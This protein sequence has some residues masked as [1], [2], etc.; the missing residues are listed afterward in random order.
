[1]FTGQKSIFKSGGGTTRKLDLGA[2]AHYR[3]IATESSV[4]PD[5]PLISNTTSN[6]ESSG[7]KEFFDFF[8][9]SSPPKTT[10]A[11]TTNSNAVDLFGDFQ[12]PAASAAASDGGFADFSKGTFFSIFINNFS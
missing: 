4:I 5:K 10:Q 3:G 8:A 11:S 9:A 7:S 1:M 2:A 6:T 12:S